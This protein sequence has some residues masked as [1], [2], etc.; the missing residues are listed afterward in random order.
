MAASKRLV[1]L[2]LLSFAVTTLHPLLLPLFPDFAHAQGQDDELLIDCF[3]F[4]G[5]VSANNT[6]CP[7]SNACCGP[8]ATCLSNRLCL[9]PGDPP[10]RLVRGPCA[11]R[12]WDDSCT[13]ICTYSDAHRSAFPCN[14]FAPLAD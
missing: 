11:V 4:D 7:N 6:K 9:N 3:R 10:S 12:G 2:H 5:Q 1:R 14:T 8:R 13:Q